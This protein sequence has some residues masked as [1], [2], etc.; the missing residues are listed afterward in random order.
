[1]QMG[2]G[3]DCGHGASNP[4]A[5]NC[6]KL[7][8]C[9]KLRKIADFTPPPRNDGYPRQGSPSTCPEPCWIKGIPFRSPGGVGLWG[10]GMDGAPPGHQ[11][12]IAGASAAVGHA[13]AAAQLQGSRRP[14]AGCHPHD[15]RPAFVTCQ[16]K[17]PRTHPPRPKKGGRKSSLDLPKCPSLGRVLSAGGH[18]PTYG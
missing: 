8:D 16:P 1:M 11:H 4:N 3:G 5:K 7:R 14:T 17:R 9:E 6:G 10:R 18:E 12:C 2:G 15:S 13:P